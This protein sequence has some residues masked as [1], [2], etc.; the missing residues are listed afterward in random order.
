MSVR[1]S[2]RR[3]CRGGRVLRRR[4]SSVRS[5]RAHTSSRA[6]S[7]STSSLSMRSRCFCAHRFEH[8]GHA[9]ATD[10]RDLADVAQRDSSM[11]RRRCARPRSRAFRHRLERLASSARSSPPLR[12]RFGIDLGLLHDAWPAQD[13]DR[14]RRP[15][16]SAALRDEISHLPMPPPICPTSSVVELASPLSSSNARRKCNVHSTLPR[17]GVAHLLTKRL[18]LSPRSSSGSLNWTSR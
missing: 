16:R 10:C 11:L 7:A 13:V 4:R 2:P 18:L 1:E 6:G 8:R 3:G 9:C 5:V 15:R 17:A 12:Q 14:V